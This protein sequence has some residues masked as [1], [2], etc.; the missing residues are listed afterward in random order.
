MRRNPRLG[1]INEVMANVKEPLILA[2]ETATRAAS[3][4]LSRGTEILSSA[5]GNA[6]ESHSIS[7][8][9]TVE[10][11][12]RQGGLKLSEIDL[13]AA[14]CRPGRFTWLPSWPE[15]THSV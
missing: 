14:A 12:L 15:T 4:A 13:F 9:E 7:L 8:L 11:I 3:V 2:I 10:N 6:A 1:S 5:Q